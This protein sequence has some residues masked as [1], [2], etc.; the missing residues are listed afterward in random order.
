MSNISD[1]SSL[2]KIINDLA[3]EIKNAWE[4]HSNIVK[5]TK[6]SKSW[7]NNKYNSNLEKYRASK[8]LVY[9]KAF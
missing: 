4:K 2:D 3:Q 1:S 6:Y 5:I 9:W 7:W 8:S